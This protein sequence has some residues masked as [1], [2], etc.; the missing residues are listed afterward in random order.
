MLRRLLLYRCP[1]CLRIFKSAAAL[2]S[3]CE[4]PS[5]RCDI[6]AKDIFGQFIDELSGGVIQ[7]TGY[8]EDGTIKYEAGKLD[9]PNHTTIGVDLQKKRVDW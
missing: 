8:N 9:M 1:G 7:A 4:S 3:H 5:V 2:V 6:K